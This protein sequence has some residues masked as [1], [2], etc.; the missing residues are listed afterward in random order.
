M[1]CADAAGESISSRQG[2]EDLVDEFGA[3]EDGVVRWTSAAEN[4]LGARREI[5]DQR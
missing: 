3:S 1:A 4:L 5:H 2:H